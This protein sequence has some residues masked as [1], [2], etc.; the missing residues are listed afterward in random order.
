VF[1]ALFVGVV[2][3]FISIKPSHD[4]PWR[5]EVAVMPRAFID[6]GRIRITGVRN[7]EYRSRDDFTVR[8]EEREVSL[9]HLNSLD[10]YLSFFWP[11]SPVGHT[12]VSFI[13]DNAP[14]ISISIETRPEIGEGFDPIPSLFKQ[15]ELIYVVGD[16]PDL[17]QFPTN[18]RKEDVFF[19]H[20]QTSPDLVR[21]F[22]LFSLARIN[23][24]GDPP[25]FYNL[26]SNSCP[27]NIAPYETPAGGVGGLDI[28][29]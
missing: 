3:W 4:R 21:R 29:H 2:G 7:F 1:A 9:S 22:F 27:I 11:D 18:Y 13:F 12:F 23:E 10:F 14:P 24:F 20:T 26:L 16:E 6:G 15:F 5:P 17:F 25:D 28:R 19:Y 8:Y